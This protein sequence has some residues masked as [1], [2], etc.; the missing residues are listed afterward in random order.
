MKKILF[1]LI[2]ATAY[3][4][5][6]C[7]CS[8]TVDAPSTDGDEKISQKNHTSSKKGNSKDS[9]NNSTGSPSDNGGMDMSNFFAD[10]PS[11]GETSFS[12]TQKIDCDFSADDEKWFI[13]KTSEEDIGDMTLTFDEKAMHILFEAT[14]RDSTEEQCQGDITAWYFVFAI[15]EGTDVEASC[16]GLE[17]TGSGKFEDPT[18]P[19]SKKKEVYAELCN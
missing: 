6:L 1:T 7:C 17:F 18:R 13:K 15:L 14:G 3:V 12:F 10:F 4:A 9:S 8:Q 5:S 11:E 16:D 19:I 2:A